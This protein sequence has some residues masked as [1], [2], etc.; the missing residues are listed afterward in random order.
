MSDPIKQK[1]IKSLGE[2]APHIEQME[3]QAFDE[4]IKCIRDNLPP[5]DVFTNA[6]L[7]KWAEANGY[8]QDLSDTEW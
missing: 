2:I 5:E 6:Q 1:I 3:E 7:E 4:M 8:V